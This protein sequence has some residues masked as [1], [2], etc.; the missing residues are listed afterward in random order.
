[1]GRDTYIRR[2]VERSTS[3]KDE[4]P[5]IAVSQQKRAPSDMTAARFVQLRFEFRARSEL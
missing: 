3:E 5:P 2:V 4:D 1:M